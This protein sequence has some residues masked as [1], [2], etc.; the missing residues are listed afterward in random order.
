MKMMLKNNTNKIIEKKKQNWKF[1][2]IEIPAIMDSGLKSI[3]GCWLLVDYAVD[4]KITVVVN[5]F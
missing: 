2:K 4:R 1:Q 5:N 3:S